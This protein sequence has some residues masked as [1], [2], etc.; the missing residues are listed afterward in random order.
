MGWMGGYVERWGGQTFQRKYKELVGCGPFNVN[1]KT[2]DYWYLFSITIG[3]CE[4]LVRLIQVVS[5]LQTRMR[6]SGVTK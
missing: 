5:K 1:V 4:S 3:Y 6:E 2:T